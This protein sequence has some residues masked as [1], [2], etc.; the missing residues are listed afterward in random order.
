MSLTP[1]GD[2]RAADRIVTG[3]RGFAESVLSI[4][5]DGF[6]AY[7]RLF[8]PAYR[9]T[10]EEWTPVPWTEIAAAN[11]TRAHAGMQLN[12]LTGSYHFMSHA[13][14]GVFDHAPEGDRS[15]PS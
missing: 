8:H 11:R 7:V 13:Q 3:L 15:R 6:S 2:T 5:P 12:A 4:V 10:G 14:P 9:R 1:A